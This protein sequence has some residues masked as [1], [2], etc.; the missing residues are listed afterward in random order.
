MIPLTVLPWPPDHR[1]WEVTHPDRLDTVVV[2]APNRAA[3]AAI[4]ADEWH[5]AP[6]G[7][8]VTTDTQETQP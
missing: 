7:Y 4:A 6:D 5:I 1:R 2:R 8:T 3:A